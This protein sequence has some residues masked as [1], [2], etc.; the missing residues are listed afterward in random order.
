MHKRSAIHK[1]LSLSGLSLP[2]DRASQ[3]EPGRTGQ[4]DRASRGK[5]GRTGQP[6]RASQGEPGRTRQPD[7]ASQGELVAQLS[8]QVPD[9]QPVEQ[10]R[11]GFVSSGVTRLCR[12]ELHVLLHLRD[13]CF[14]LSA[15]LR[16]LVQF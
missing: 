4:P 9:P 15:C 6:D 13:L 12:A 14:K 10:F 5:P 1:G 2:G 11:Y 16:S 3:G 8:A 7:R